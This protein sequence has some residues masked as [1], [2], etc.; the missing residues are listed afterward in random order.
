MKPETSQKIRTFTEHTLKQHQAHSYETGL[1]FHEIQQQIQNTPSPV[2]TMIGT[3]HIKNTRLNPHRLANI[4][5]VCQTIKSDWKYNK[6]IKC[7]LTRYY[8]TGDSK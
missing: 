1:T 2:M 7:N 4:L 3:P 6:D 8:L 5:R